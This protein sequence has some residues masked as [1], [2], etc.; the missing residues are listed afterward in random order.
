[1]VLHTAALSTLTTAVNGWRI[2]SHPCDTPLSNV[3]R[4]GSRSPGCHT[5]Q[6]P[7]QAA[8]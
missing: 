2:R 7:G 3:S 8:Y 1:M 4:P 5:A 6:M